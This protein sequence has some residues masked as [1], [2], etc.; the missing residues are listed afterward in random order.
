V[1]VWSTFLPPVPVFKKKGRNL[2]DYLNIPILT[3]TF[4]C[5]IRSTLLCHLEFILCWG[6]FWTTRTMSPDTTALGWCIQTTG[7]LLLQRSLHTSGARLLPFAELALLC[8]SHLSYQA[9]G[10]KQYVSGLR[11]GGTWF[12]FRPGHWLSCLKFFVILFRLSRQLPLLGHDHFFLSSSP[13]TNRPTAQR[14]EVRDIG[15]II[16]WTI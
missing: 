1:T 14:Y 13:L 2:C 6:T 7:L 5:C 10:L 15:S 16:K 3:A 11:S 12:E 8:S 9:S 4:V